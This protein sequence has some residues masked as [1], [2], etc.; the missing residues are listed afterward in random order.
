MNKT[1]LFAIFSFMMAS[2]ALLTSCSGNDN[3]E[4]L[5]P[6]SSSSWVEPYSIMGSTMG[7]VKLF[8]ASNK[9]YS[10]KNTQANMLT[11]S[12]GTDMCGIIYCFSPVTGELY[13][14]I[15]TEPISKKNIIVKTLKE[16]Y[17]YLEDPETDNTYYYNSDKSLVETVN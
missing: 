15:D 1:I 6:D 10:L 9:D 8:M 14:V 12:K 5:I 7:Q 2:S 4:E 17:S 13:S 3:I 11:Y 16:H